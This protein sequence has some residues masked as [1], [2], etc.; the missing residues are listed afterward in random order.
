MSGMPTKYYLVLKDEALFWFISRTAMA[1]T[2]RV[3]FNG[4][5]FV[6]SYSHNLLL[7]KRLTDAGVDVVF[8]KQQVHHI[9]SSFLD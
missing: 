2:R 9:E 5:L 4:A 7:V 8:G 1:T 6:P 3:F